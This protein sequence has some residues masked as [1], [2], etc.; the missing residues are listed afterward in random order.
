MTPQ[1][2]PIVP[3]LLPGDVLVFSRKGLFDSIIRVK[4][5]SPATHIEIA[6]GGGK[7]VASRN[8]KGCEIYPI[9]LDGLYA[10]LRPQFPFDIDAALADFHEKYEGKPYGWIALFSF[11]CIDIHDK[12]LFCSELATLFLRGGK[13]EPFNPTIRAEI[14]SPG[15]FL[16]THWSVL[17]PIWTKNPSPPQES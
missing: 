10:V 2:T 6:I 12:G 16:Y 17:K 8:G 14:V 11:C 5:W 13:M 3:D 9:D 7:T 4:T 1:L 15:N